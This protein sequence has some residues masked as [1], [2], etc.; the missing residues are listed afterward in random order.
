MQRKHALAL[1]PARRLAGCGRGPKTHPV[2]GKRRA[3]RRRHRTSHGQPRRGGATTDPTIRAAGVIQSDGSFKLETP[4]AGATIRGGARRGIT[5]CASDLPTMTP[6]SSASP[7][8]RSRLASY[9]SPRRVC[10]SRCRRMTASS[11][12][13]RAVITLSSVA[14][15]ARFRGESRGVSLAVACLICATNPQLLRGPAQILG[16][17]EKNHGGTGNTGNSLET[18]RVESLAGENI[19]LILACLFPVFPVPPVVPLDLVA[20]WPRRVHPCSSVVHSFGALGFSCASR[21]TPKIRGMFV[22]AI[23]T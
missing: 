19:D 8:R 12:G 6:R 4:H 20:A 10:R 3:A 21:K 1:G 2:A 16:D 17:G 7:P 23:V 13:W 15:R 14:A 11:W 5:V 22:N 18:F 9:S